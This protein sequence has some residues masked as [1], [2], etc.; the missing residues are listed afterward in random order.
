MNDPCQIPIEFYAG[1]TFIP[2]PILWLDVYSFPID[3]TNYSALMTARHTVSTN[4]PPLFIASSTIGQIILGGT[5]GT[6]QIYL[7][8]NLT[9][10]LPNPSCNYYDIW[11][12][13]PAGA[14]TR[15]F[16][17]PLIVKQPVTRA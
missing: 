4:D 15:L 7:N 14:A 10:N 3:L 8:S 6:I 9:M 17:G 5:L 1:E 2:P 16:G 13:S 11:V 12:Y